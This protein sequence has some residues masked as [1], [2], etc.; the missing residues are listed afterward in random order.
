LL[1][2]AGGGGVVVNPNKVKAI[3]E[4]RR[5]TDKIEAKLLYELLRMMGFRVRYTCPARQ[6]GAAWAV[7]GPAPAAQCPHEV[8]SWGAGHVAAGGRF[9]SGWR[10]EDLERLGWSMTAQLPQHASAGDFKFGSQQLCGT[11]TFDPVAE[12]R[13]GAAGEQ[14]AEEYPVPR[15]KREARKDLLKNTGQ[16]RTKVFAGT[17]VNGTAREKRLAEKARQ[18]EWTFQLDEPV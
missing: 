9:T 15:R 12:Q 16:P 13:T 11:D 14:P 8:V 7:G 2:E 3:A 17:Q 6:P 4:S 5:K 10:A 1:E 18:E